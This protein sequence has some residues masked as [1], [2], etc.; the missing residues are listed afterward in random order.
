MIP[1]DCDLFA[2]V[3]L[4]GTKIAAVVAGKDGV[5][6]SEGVIPT[7]AEEG[8]E[9]AVQRTCKLLNDLCKDHKQK[10]RA[11]GI[12]LPGLID[13]KAGKILFLPNLP[14]SWRGFP[15]SAAFVE[16][17]GRPVFL[18]NDA[19]MAALGE[20]TY[21]SSREGE[22]L[23]FVTVGTGIGGGLVLDGKLR[24]G[25]FGAAGAS[26]HHTILPDGPPC[27]CGANGCLET[28]V[29]GPAL[30]RAGSALM[31]QGLAPRLNELTQ[32]DPAGHGYAH[33]PRRTVRR[34]G[35]CC[36]NRI[37]GEIPGPRHCQCRK[38]HGGQACG[39]RRRTFLAGRDAVSNQCAGR[40]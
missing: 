18:L 34:S 10:H 40:C 14:I 6:L 19:R 8:S 26:G 4:G 7:Q 20:F 35:G 29:S 39:D 21:G 37:C 27:S 3:D 1:D 5:I 38:H 22:D 2:G 28:L 9:Q 24:L 16:E 15:I 17:G 36:G 11:I 30:A 32:G 13:G 33:G 31:K 12:G 25:A 23:L